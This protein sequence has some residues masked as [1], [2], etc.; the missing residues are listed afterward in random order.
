MFAVRKVIKHSHKT[1]SKLE[2]ERLKNRAKAKTREQKSN[3]IARAKA[4]E[5]LNDE[6]AE[7]NYFRTK[8]KSRTLKP[9]SDS[10]SGTHNSELVQSDCDD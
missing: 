7:E 3:Q 9:D 10:A 4:L 5:A 2:Q 8:N 6:R 1:K